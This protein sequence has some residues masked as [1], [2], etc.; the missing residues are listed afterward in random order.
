M[1]KRARQDRLTRKAQIFEVA[2]RI[3]CEKGFEAASMGDIAEATGLTKAGLYHHIESKEDLLYAIMAYGMELFEEKVLRR[4]TAIQDPL[5]RLRETFKGHVLVVTRDR[6]KEITVVLHESNA[7]RGRSREKINARKR[8]YVQF[9]EKTFRE[10][11]KTG[12]ARAIDPALAAYGMLGMINWIYQW[13]RPAG[14]LSETELADQL[15]DLFLSGVLK[16]A[17]AASS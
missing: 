13:H 17:A 7:L 15:C 3:F 6:P 8:R 14:R 12:A 16:P 9:L 2:A 11:V 10:L 1:K 5:E 4:V